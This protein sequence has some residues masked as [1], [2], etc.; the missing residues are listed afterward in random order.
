MELFSFYMQLKLRF[1]FARALKLCHQ[2]DLLNQI[3]TF[4]RGEQRDFQMK[5]VKTCLFV[6]EK[7]CSNLNDG[8]ALRLLLRRVNDLSVSTGG[9]DEQARRVGREEAQEQRL[10]DGQRN[11]R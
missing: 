9:E 5:V 4:K 8:V 3:L 6:G 7:N 1:D 2:S 11:R 10:I